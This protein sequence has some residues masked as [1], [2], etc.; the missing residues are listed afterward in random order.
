MKNNTKTIVSV[1]IVVL[2]L[3]ALFYFGNR[4]K[5]GAPANTSAD[6]SVDTMHTNMG[7]DKN[8]ALTSL[9]NMVGKPL[10]SF[11]LTDRNG[12]VY[13]SDSLRGKNVVLFFSEGL[14]CYPACWNQ[15]VALAKDARFKGSDTTVLTILVDA[16][17]DWQ[18]AIEKM[19]ELSQATVVFDTGAT[20]SK[21]F[22][23]LNMPSSMHPGSL[24][25][26]TFV[27]VDKEGIIRYV[28]DDPQM[29]VRNDVLW[30]EVE[31]LK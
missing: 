16:K 29:G 14:M 27:V 9:N 25:G 8:T 17:E 31:K 19:P 20:V 12:K 6:S 18:K 24:P 3:G 1:I 5:T 7:M 21:E 15:M 28:F 22:N 23:M 4:N 2:A 26:H 13:S 30:T 11:S 10:P